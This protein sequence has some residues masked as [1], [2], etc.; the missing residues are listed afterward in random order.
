[1]TDSMIALAVVLLMASPLVLPVVSA[2]LGSYRNS[3]IPIVEAQQW[4]FPP[5]RI[6]EYF[7][8]F[9]FGARQGD[10]VWYGGIY[11]VEETFSKTGLSPWADFVYV[12]IPLLLGF[13][14]FLRSKKEWKDKFIIFSLT[15]AF[16]LALGKFTPLYK[17]LYYL[18]PGFK[19]FR[20]PEKFLFW[21]NFW[22][23]LGGCSGLQFVLSE[24]ERALRL[25]ANVLRILAIILGCMII[26]LLFLFLFF[27]SALVGYIQSKGSLLNGDEVFMWEGLAIGLALSVVLILLACIHFFKSSPSRIMVSFF[28]VTFL[29]F[30]V[31]H[32][33]IT[34][35]IP[36]GDLMKVATWDEKLPAFDTHEWRIFSTGKFLYPVS[37]DGP[38]KDGFIA[39]KLMEYSTLDC[40]APTLKK[41]RTVSGFS[42]VM[43]KGYVQYM[44]FDR[45]D[46]E[47]VLDLL[48]VRYVAIHTVPESSLP[49]GTRIIGRDEAGEFVFLENTDALPRIGTSS[50]F[51]K[52]KKDEADKQV[53]DPKRDI[54]SNFVLEDLP[55]N[56]SKGI[57]CSK[58]ATAAILDEN[59]NNIRIKVQNGP[60]WVIL[61]DWFNPGWTCSSNGKNLQIVKADGGLMAVFCPVKDAIL[62]FNYF[63]PG[64]RQGL[65]LLG[66]GLVLLVAYLIL[67]PKITRMLD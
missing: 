33:V 10:G 29:N 27:Q 19:M 30:A 18:L 53:F 62:E 24:K 22:L 20:H 42:P 66:I 67:H 17:C 46:P 2:S 44:N 48:S 35:T 8:P 1:M 7:I 13:C 57:K 58:D 65:V 12:G 52:S 47:R 43:D 38:L 4:S 55:G 40:N 49:Q 32:H 51:I 60:C 34:W 21:V 64:L 54:H 3:G 41:I 45:H 56:Y 39:R 63:P 6:V 25:I 61:R 28:I 23:I 9:I 11:N 26:Y 31:W 37:V 14:L 16:F 59:P 50:E 5:L 36:A 15:L